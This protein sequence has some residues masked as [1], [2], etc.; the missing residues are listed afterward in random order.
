MILRYIFFADKV[1]IQ[2]ITKQ[3]SFSALVGPNSGQVRY[4]S[5]P[6]YCQ[7]LKCR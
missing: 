7:D 4:I 2:D 1:E 5:I 6:I 3:T